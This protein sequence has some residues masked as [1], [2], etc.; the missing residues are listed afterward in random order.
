[1]SMPPHTRVLVMGAAAGV[2]LGVAYTLSPLTVLMLPVLWL[3]ARW[4]GRELD[5]RERQFVYALLAAA[6]AVRLAAIAGLFLAHDDMQPF[7]TFFGDEEMFKS[8]SIWL[9]NIGLGVPISAADFIYAVEETGKSHYLF[10][11]AYLEALTGDAPYGIHVFNMVLYL[12]GVLMLFRAVRRS[13]GSVPA[14]G[15]LAVLLLLPSLFVWSISALKEPLYT[16][17]AAAELLCVLQIVRS[18]TWTGRLLAV[19]GVAALGIMLESLRKG[20][21]LVA[22][23]GAV[24][25]LTAAFVVSRPRL[26]L[27]AAVAAPLGALAVLAV[28]GVQ[29]RAL[30]VLHDSAI[31]HIGHVF[32]PGY[33]YR[34]LDEWYYINPADIRRMPWGDAL[35]YVMRSLAAFVVQ[36]LPWQIESRTALVYVPEYV[37]WLTMA[38]L[39]PVGLFA[40]LRRDAVL[41]CVLLAHAAAIV[42]MVALT[43]GNVGTLIRH[44][45]LALPYLVWLSALGA[46]EAVRRLAS[47][48]APGRSQLAYA[49][50]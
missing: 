48:Q 34:T 10:L 11:L 43:S 40:G 37:V 14:I 42:L 30:N 6:V 4:A 5:A 12:T 13:F 32:T 41:T 24:G 1:M 23:I 46:C 16:F 49:D 7:A 33:S 27:A 45:G 28:P 31:Y 9:R 35:T 39:V 8:R 15:G 17:L 3:A 38:A 22:A 25:G 20:G 21:I 29:E 36:P 44:R 19:I 2:G 26:L 50:R 47:Q 18:R